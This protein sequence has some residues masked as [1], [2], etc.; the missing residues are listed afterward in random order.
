MKKLLCSLLVIVPLVGLG[1]AFDNIIPID[2][3]VH[4]IFPQNTM[5]VKDLG[6][7]NIYQFSC[8]LMAERPSDVG[9]T[10]SLT[11]ANYIPD[12]G[13]SGDGGGMVTSNPTTFNFK[14]KMKSPKAG[15]AFFNFFNSS[16]D[17]KYLIS[18]LYA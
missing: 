11:T 6:N 4:K 10:Y 13:Y 15:A 17:K 18:C 5:I 14:G 7:D 1:K 16:L 12:R 2:G 3:S 8:W 9:G